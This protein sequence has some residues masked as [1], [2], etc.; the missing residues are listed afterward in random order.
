[1]QDHSFVNVILDICFQDQGSTDRPIGPGPGFLN[2]RIGFGPWIPAQDM[3][4]FQKKH[5]WSLAATKMQ[6]ASRS[7]LEHLIKSM[8][9][10]VKLDFLVMVNLPVMILMNVMLLSVHVVKI[11]NA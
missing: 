4:V 7:I 8:V 5:V 9:V 6:I 1:M 2:F 3:I 10:N 11:A